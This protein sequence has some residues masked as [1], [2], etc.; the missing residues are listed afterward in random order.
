MAA[1][2]P[3]QIRPGDIVEFRLLTFQRNQVGITTQHLKYLRADAEDPRIDD[4]VHG[5]GDFIAPQFKLMLNVQCQYVGC[6]GRIIT[7]VP[8]SVLFF[9]AIHQGAGTGGAH[10]A[11]Q[12]VS[13]LVSFYSLTPGAT[14]RGRNYIPFPAME[15]IDE[16]A[17]E[18]P[19][20]IYRGKLQGW[21]D[22]FAAEVN[23]AYDGGAHTAIFDPVIWSRKSN[24]FRYITAGFG[25]GIWATQR[26]RG[27]YGR[28]NPIPLS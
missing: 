9:D 18:I 27:D 1:P 28:P 7:T 5:F 13:G 21:G 6:D 17:P 26:R 4:I 10:M 16:L 20:A 15:D 25:R 14:G 2:A 3:P 11:P 19:T 8:K 12:Q 23:I 22:L 24:T